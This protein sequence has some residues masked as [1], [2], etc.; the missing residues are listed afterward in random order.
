MH[1][2]RKL[3]FSGSLD[4]RLL[5]AFAVAYWLLG[6]LEPWSFPGEAGGISRLA[7]G[8][9]ALGFVSIHGIT[10]YGWK[11][12]LVWAGIT[13]VISWSAE[14]L[15]IAV[16]FPF[17]D[18]HY[19]DILGAKIGVVPWSIMPAYFMTGYFA[20]TIA[21]I[22]LR[23]LGAGIE[24]RDVLV[25]PVIAGFVMVM[26][27]FC[28]DPVLSTVRGAWIWEE[29]GPYFG[30]PISNYVGW[31][32]TVFLIYQAFAL[33]LRRFGREQSP[34]QTKS[35]WILAPI[36]YLGTALEYLLNPFAQSADL[37]IHRS[38]FLVAAMT[39]VFVSILSVV[40]V[41]RLD[42]NYFEPGHT[43]Q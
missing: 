14:T 16:G 25:L 5:I 22:F 7:Q 41:T 21:T 33:Y 36:M 26:W 39:M 24:R 13:F 38:M 20:W 43:R 30:V 1:V 29:G 19:T 42:S 15:S 10:R 27:D 37:D 34:K 8:V 35:F 18:Y 3:K 2:S 9:A 6:L 28:F 31:Y 23:N 17:G 40:T 4:T 11:S 12:M 32:L